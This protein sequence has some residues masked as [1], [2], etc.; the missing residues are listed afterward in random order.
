MRLPTTLQH[1][2]FAAAAGLL[3][4][5]AAPAQTEPL[6]NDTFRVV[7][8]Q[9]V[10][11]HAMD[12]NVRILDV[13]TSVADY[14][15]GH[16]PNAVFL[17]NDALRIPRAGL[18]VQYHDPEEMAAIFRRAGVRSEDTVV[19]YGDADSVLGATM[20]AYCLNRIGHD[21]T[22]V[23]DGG[24]DAYRLQFPL[25]QHYPDITVGDISPSFDASVRATL[26]D[27][28]R[29]MKNP[30]AFLL[31]TRPASDYL[32]NTS[33]WMRNG[34]IP[35]A[36]NLDWH[37]LM[38]SKNPHQFKPLSAMRSLIES[39]GVERSDDVIVYC[40]TS[41]E[42]TL[43]YHVMRNLLG[44]PNVRLYEGSWT[45]YSSKMDMTVERDPQ[46]LVTG[47]TAHLAP[48]TRSSSRTRAARCSGCTR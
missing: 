9:W 17:A 1:L 38:D 33:R 47:A 7:S 20:T 10:A 14:Q 44:Y 46:G 37:Q 11:R 32:G 22:A 48:T 36:V 28:R 30:S 12:S 27:V 3:I 35:G 6:G 40:G 41:R 4:A 39:T 45:E 16:I 42:A 25:T 18:P 5:A 31:D 23:I 2:A 29:A 43:V 26:D 21:N 13:R 8:P 15:F 34:H 19:I 24:F